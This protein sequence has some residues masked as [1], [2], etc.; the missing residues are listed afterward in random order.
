MFVETR[1]GPDLARRL[2]AAAAG[3]GLPPG[4]VTYVAGGVDAPER[5]LR[6][7]GLLPPLPPPPAPAAEVE[8]EEK[9]KRR[10][11]KKT[12]APPPDSTADDR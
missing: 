12:S 3:A 11:R 9:P 6:A 10:P 4:A 7:V 2:L 8:A 5:V 1:T